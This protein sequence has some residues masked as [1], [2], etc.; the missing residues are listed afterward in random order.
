MMRLQ[1]FNPKRFMHYWLLFIGVY[2]VF[3]LV[4][5]WCNHRIVSLS[6]ILIDFAFS[7]LFAISFYFIN[8]K[9]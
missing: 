2:L 3:W 6:S 5:I 9:T 8:G 4:D 7:L 1:K